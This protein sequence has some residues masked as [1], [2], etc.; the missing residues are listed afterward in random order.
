MKVLILYVGGTIGMQPTSQGYAPVAGYLT[1]QLPLILRQHHSELPV[2]DILEYSPLLDSANTVP[3]DWVNIATDIVKHYAAYDGFLVLHGTDTMAYTASALSFML[4]HLAKPVICT[5]SQL[6][7]CHVRSD[8]MQN[9]IDSL[10]YI[11]HYSISEVCLYFDRVLLRGNRSRK[12]DASQIHAFTSPNYPVLGHSG[13]ELQ[14]SSHLVL[15][16]PSAPLQLQVIHHPLIAH[17]SLFPGISVTILQAILEQPLDG[18][19]LA[20]YGAGNAPS[21]PRLLKTLQ[22]ATHRGITILN[23]TQCWQGGVDMKEYATGQMLAECGVLSGYDM[24]PEAA[25]T[26]LYYLFSTDLSRAEIRRLAEQNIRGELTS[27]T[28]EI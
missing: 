24:T 7:L 5:G 1:E 18:L 23:V 2:V 19:V 11:K 26:K 10:L 21:D 17:M 9:I 22:E 28:L 4:Q 6:P 20:T 15:A 12:T 14:L 8:A 16:K 3:Q 25:L 27:A 13:V